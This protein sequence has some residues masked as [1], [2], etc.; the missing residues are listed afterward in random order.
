MIIARIVDEGVT[1]FFHAA[2]GDFFDQSEEVR[3]QARAN[4]AGSINFV[5]YIVPVLAIL[6]GALIFWTLPRNH[7]C[8]V[9]CV[10]DEEYPP[11]NW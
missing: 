10:S 1:T 8:F 3:Q 4:F 11:Y 6:V 7:R 5:R 9:G 2:I